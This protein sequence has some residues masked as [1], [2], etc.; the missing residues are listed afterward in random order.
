LGGLGVGWVGGWAH[1]GH[2]VEP[3]LQLV[4]DR[5]GLDV[6]QVFVILVLVVALFVDF[7]HH[8]WHIRVLEV[9]Q[10]LDRLLAPAHAHR[11]AMDHRRKRSESL[12][13]VEQET[14]A[15]VGFPC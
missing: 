6:D 3:L 1:E 15:L 13:P 4:L 2:A 14:G 11:F 8:G 12:L 5:V 10:K 7:G 9:G